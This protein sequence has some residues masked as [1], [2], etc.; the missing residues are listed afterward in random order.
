MAA[1]IPV[2]TS[3]VSSMPEV[4][5]ETGIL[6]DPKSVDD[7]EAGLVEL[8]ENRSAAQQRTEAAYERASRFTWKDSARA[9][10]EVYRELAGEA[11]S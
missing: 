2:L 4:V 8:I 10:A 9:L 6:V 7:I 1:R 11:R 3:N 5:G